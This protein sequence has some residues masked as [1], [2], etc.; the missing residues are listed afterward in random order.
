MATTYVD[1][2]TR[3]EGHMAVEVD[4]NAGYTTGTPTGGTIT[5]AKVKG[6]MYR[7]FENI[8]KGRAPMDAIEIVQRI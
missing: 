1:P 6:E 3:I 7:G 8:L 2:V 4:S 5:S